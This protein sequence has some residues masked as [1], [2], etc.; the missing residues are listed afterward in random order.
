MGTFTDFGA[1]VR[2]ANEWY[3][4]WARRMGRGDVCCEGTF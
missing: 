3:V 4:M 1:H 2:H